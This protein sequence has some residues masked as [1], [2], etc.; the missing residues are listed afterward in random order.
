MKLTELTKH[1]D[2]N[3]K[4]KAAAPY[5]SGRFVKIKI[6]YLCFIFDSLMVSEKNWFSLHSPS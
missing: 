5:R 4:N 6:V 1:N 2:N 3:M